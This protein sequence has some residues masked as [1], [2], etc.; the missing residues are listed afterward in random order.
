MPCFKTFLSTHMASDVSDMVEFTKPNA[1]ECFPDRN[2]GTFEQAISSPHN[3]SD[4]Y[5]EDILHKFIFYAE[6]G[7]RDTL[8]YNFLDAVVLPASAIHVT[9]MAAVLGY[10][11][12][13]VPM[14]YSP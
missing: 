1:G 10:P 11:I 6:K 8:E 9:S 12:I 14:G 7:L 5:Q 3:A 2:I 4:E 13:T